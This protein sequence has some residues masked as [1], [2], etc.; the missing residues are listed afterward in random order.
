MPR[1]SSS[2]TRLRW[3]AVAAL[4]ASMNTVL[5]AAD[6]LLKTAGF[7]MIDAGE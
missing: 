3:A 5:S 2:L 7:M 1:A 4:A 6:S